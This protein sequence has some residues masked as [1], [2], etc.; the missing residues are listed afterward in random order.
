MIDNMVKID[1]NSHSILKRWKEKLRK[2]GLKVSLGATIREMEK[3]VKDE[4]VGFSKKDLKEISNALE[5][6]KETLEK[7]NNPTFSDV[8]IKMDTMIKEKKR[9]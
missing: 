8:V 7:Y 3:M 4:N 2:Q 5:K 6:L 9:K 1:A